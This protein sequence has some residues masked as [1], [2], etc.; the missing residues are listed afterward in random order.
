MED[1]SP[2]A[3]RSVLASNINIANFYL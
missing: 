3:I 2:S 1:M